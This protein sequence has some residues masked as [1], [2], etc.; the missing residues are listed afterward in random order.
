MAYHTSIITF[1]RTYDVLAPSFVFGVRRAVS[2]SH[3]IGPWEYDL[4][5]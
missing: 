1:D 3:A 4:I 5:I 2:S